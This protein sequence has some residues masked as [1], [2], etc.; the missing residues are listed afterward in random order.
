MNDNSEIIHHANGAT[1]LVGPD[2]VNFYRACTLKSSLGLWL[3]TKM[4]PTRGMT[5]TRMLGL[6]PEYTGKKYTTRQVDAAI[7]DL[8]VWICT[9][10]A[11]LPRTRERGPT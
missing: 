4:V 7:A 11:A 5:I 3:K 9:M 2:A 1:S 6:V 10:R 8:D